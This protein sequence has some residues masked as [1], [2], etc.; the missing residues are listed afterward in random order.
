ME[1][2]DYTVDLRVVRKVEKTV[3][4]HSRDR[5]MVKAENGLDAE[6]HEVTVQSVEKDHR[7]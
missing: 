5:A 4:A 1:E 7:G 3:H 2:S 6:G